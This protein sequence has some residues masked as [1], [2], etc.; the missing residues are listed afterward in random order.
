MP[1]PSPSPLAAQDPLRKVRSL[2]ESSGNS[3]VAVRLS[4]PLWHTDTGVDDLAACM[5]LQVLLERRGADAGSIA[6]AHPHLQPLIDQ[7][8]AAEPLPLMQSAG[9]TAVCPLVAQHLGHGPTEAVTGPDGKP[10]LPLSEL[11]DHMAALNQLLVIATQLREDVQGR[12][13]KYTAHKLALL[14][15]AV[16]LSRLHR[17]TLRRRIEEHFEDVKSATERDGH[18]SPA[19]PP[20]LV[21]WLVSLCDDICEMVRSFPPLL[22]DRLQPSFEMVSG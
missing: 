5:Q 19:L 13:F 22:R 2:F 3:P 1:P 15:Q 18:G 20:P 4:E 14:Y 11:L 21:E 17:D 9:F 10:V 16:N 7:Q 6:A 12:L 8:V